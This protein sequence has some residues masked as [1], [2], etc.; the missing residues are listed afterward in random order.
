AGSIRIAGSDVTVALA[1]LG[2]TGSFTLSRATTST[3]SVTTAVG[4]ADATV[5]LGGSDVMSGVTG[6]LLI[7]PD[8]LAGTLRGSVSLTELLPAGV[9]LSG[10]FAVVINQQEQ[11]LSETIVVA[12]TPVVIDVPAGPFIGISATGATLTV[13]GQVLTGDLSL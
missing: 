11:G 12:G 7:T 8:G 9:G 4:I 5:T 3:G 1:G 2:I 6:A 10:T 13:A